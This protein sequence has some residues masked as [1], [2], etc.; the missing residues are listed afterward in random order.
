MRHKFFRIFLVLMVTVAIIAA[1]GCGSSASGDLTVT[2][3]V[4]GGHSHQITIAG[5]DIRT[6]PPGQKVIISTAVGTPSHTHTVTLTTQ[7]YT[8][9]GNG[10]PVTKTSSTDAGHSHDFSIIKTGQTGG[11]GGY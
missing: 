9:I 5:T 2:S 1:P 10:L 6:P 4:V 3:S 7:D 11:G 8:D